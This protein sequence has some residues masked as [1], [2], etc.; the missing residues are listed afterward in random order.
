MG[1]DEGDNKDETCG[2]EWG[3]CVNVLRS[4]LCSCELWIN[5]CMVVVIIVVWDVSSPQAYTVVVN[6]VQS[7]IH[8]QKTSRI[9]ACICVLKWFS[10][11]TP[12]R[13]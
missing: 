3:I 8:T 1:K 4:S 11:S 9:C 2:G 7:F 10:Q 13:L 5:G 6:D 12:S